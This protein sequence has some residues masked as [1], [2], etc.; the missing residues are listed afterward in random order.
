[1]HVDEILTRVKSLDDLQ[2]A[3][4]VLLSHIF[5]IRKENRNL[6]RRIDGMEKSASQN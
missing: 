4:R 1:M 5:T 3:K 2:E 6:I